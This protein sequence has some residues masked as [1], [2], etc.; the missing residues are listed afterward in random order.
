MELKL[1]ELRAA[2]SFLRQA[3]LLVNVVGSLFFNADKDAAARMR[4]IELYLADEVEFVERVPKKKAP[5]QRYSRGFEF[6][7]APTQRP[8]GET[9]ACSRVGLRSAFFLGRLAFCI[10]PDL[11]IYQA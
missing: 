6:L 7:Q 5:A 9:K 2:S 8:G 1:P 3:R 10:T 4:D 11:R